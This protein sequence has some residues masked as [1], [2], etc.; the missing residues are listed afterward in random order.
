MKKLTAVLA[1][2]CTALTSQAF[3]YPVH[4]R[5]LSN[6]L[7][8]IVCEKN[9]NDFAEVEVWYRTGSKDE[10][11][12]IRGMAH[13]FEHMMFRGTE[14]YP[15]DAVFKNFD[16][17]G[18][19]YNAYTTFDRTVYHEYIPVSALEL[20]LDMEADRMNNLVVTQSILNT[21]REV[22]GE[23]Y[24]N[25]IN[26]WYQ[27][28]LQERHKHLYPQGHP[29]EVEVIGHLDEI[30]S[31]T[32]EQCMSFYNSYYSPNNAFL[33]VT[34]NV[35]AEEVFRLAEKYFG[36][37]KKQLSIPPATGVPDLSQARVRA[38]EMSIDFPVQIYSFVYPN[39][40]TQSRDFF[41]L[42]L[43]NSI[44][45]TDNSSILKTRLMKKEHSAYFISSAGMEWSL[46]PYMDVIDI[47]MPASPGNVKVKKAVR[48]EL[49][50]IISEGISAERLQKAVN[51]MEASYTFGEYTCSTVAHRLGLAE[52]YFHDYRQDEKLI[53][54]YRKVTPEDIKAVAA[55]YFAED[56]LQ[57]I[58]IKPGF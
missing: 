49:D 42:S 38:T 34:G 46:Y 10:K 5:V 9:D 28:V 37:V 21:E 12:G 53:E 20:A 16:K 41:A 54:S 25:G 3:R 30:T 58:N 52:L 4:S 7:K 40:G 24:R 43:L 51:A 45:I 35:K 23:E 22:V 11:P 19:D 47:L 56:K 50:R 15:G 39:P 27:K 48:E 8:V 36:P 33:V 26:N 1:L 6:G 29:Y 14:R 44:L 13:L 57:L 31:C 32:A 2:L 55:R 18:G 17:V